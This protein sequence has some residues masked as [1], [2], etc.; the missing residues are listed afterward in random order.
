MSPMLPKAFVASFENFIHENVTHE[1]VTQKDYVVAHPYLP[2]SHFETD[3]NCM[4]SGR[5]P[6][7]GS[8]SFP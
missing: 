3:T 8:A 6:G 2:L 5:G 1:N 7:H 4:V